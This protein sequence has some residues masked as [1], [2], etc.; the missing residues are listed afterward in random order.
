[1]DARKVAAEAA[2]LKMQWLLL[3][4]NL[5]IEQMAPSEERERS[6]KLEQAIGSVFLLAAQL[7]MA[8]VLGIR[9][10]FLGVVH[11]RPTEEDDD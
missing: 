3:V 11:Q 2:R 5:G 1:M 7:R 8:D 6:D 10:E 4:R 9:N